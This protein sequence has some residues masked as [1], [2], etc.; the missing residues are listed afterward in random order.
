MKTRTFRFALQLG[1]VAL[2]VASPVVAQQARAPQPAI[3]A[4]SRPAKSAASTED[5]VK[6]EFAQWRYAGAQIGPAFARGPLS[7]LSVST[8]DEFEQV[9]KFYMSCIPT[10]N[11]LPLASSWDI[12]GDN[13]M[14]GA[15]YNLGSSY[16]LSLNAAPRDSGT[17]IYQKGT[18]NI[19]IEIRA[20]TPEQFK[21]T[22]SQTDIRFIKMRPLAGAPAPKTTGAPVQTAPAPASNW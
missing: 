6:A 2:A 20:R 5:K 11:K 13:T 10:D 19:V 4:S 9:W 17:I 21:A 12:P 15:N 22:G 1:I 16:A 14:V 7:L 18:E 3:S 8:P